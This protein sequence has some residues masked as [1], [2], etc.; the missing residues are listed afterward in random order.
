MADDITT[1]YRE[2]RARVKETRERLLITRRQI[3]DQT[4]EA[5]LISEQL[6]F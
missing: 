4:S 2:A 6:R 3:A 5:P 1:R